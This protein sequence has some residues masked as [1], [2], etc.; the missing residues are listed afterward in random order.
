MLPPIR[1][2]H[3]LPLVDAK[4]IDL[5]RSLTAREWSAPTVAPAWTVKDVAAHLLDTQQRL[6]SRLRGEPPPAPPAIDSD[7]DLVAFINRLNAAGVARYGRLEPA[8]LIARLEDGSQPYAA[9]HQSLDP[10]A[11]APYAVSWAGETRSANWFHTA[12]E[13]T[14]RWHHQQQ[15]RLAV[16]R[17][18][19]MT[20][21][22]YHPVL[23]CFM[24]ALPFAYRDH[25]REPGT[26]ARFTVDGECGGSWYLSREAGGWDLIPAPARHAASETRI[27]Q[28]IA[29]RIF[30]KGIGR[31]AAA[32]QV[33]VSGDADLGGHVLG[34]I[35][36]VG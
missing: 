9:H 10:L 28:E 33:G 12:R 34:M 11:E 20:H 1:T 36:I 29:W 24:R 35:A 22:L 6:V 16:A 30:T 27:P 31:D 25:T 8:E 13:L 15:I 19:I 5:L 17:P 4:L 26:V 2:A 21:E 3:L 32:E 14:E 23:D 7:A 18:G